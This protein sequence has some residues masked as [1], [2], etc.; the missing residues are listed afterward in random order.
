MMKQPSHSYSELELCLSWT[1]FW[2]LGFCLTFPHESNDENYTSAV[3]VAC[4]MMRQP[5]HSYSELEL[6]WSCMCF[7]HC[8]FVWLFLMKA[9]MKITLPPLLWHVRWWDNPVIV[10]LSLKCVCRE[11]VFGDWASVWPFLM[12]AMM[13]ITLPPLLWHVRWWDNPVIVTLSL[14]WLN[15]TKNAKWK[16]EVSC[17]NGHCGQVSEHFCFAQ[18]AAIKNWPWHSKVNKAYPPI[19]LLECLEPRRMGI[20]IC[21]KANHQI[22]EFSLEKTMV[23]QEYV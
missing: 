9:M 5:S 2:P 10:T 14:N 7:F 4:P 3:A 15:L 21:R 20:R 12:K 17:F 16:K 13:K 8:A 1:W 22:R 19:G 18:N 11:R 6:C 23:F